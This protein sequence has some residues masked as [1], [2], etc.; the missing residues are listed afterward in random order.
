MWRPERRQEDPLKTAEPVEGS[1]TSL[2]ETMGKSMQLS[3]RRFVQMAGISAGAVVGGCAVGTGTG[4]KG[5]HS[6]RVSAPGS[7]AESPFDVGIDRQLFID[8]QLIDRIANAVFT[9]NPPQRRELVLFPET[10]WERGGITCYA[11][12]FWDEMHKQFRLYYVPTCPAA[13]PTFR[14]ALATSSDGIHW[15]RP[16]LGIVEFNGSRHNNIVIDGEREGSVFI[17]PNAPPERRYGYLSGTDKTGLCYYCSADGIHFTTGKAP[18]TPYQSDSQLSTFWDPARKKYVSYFKATNEAPDQWR[19]SPQIVLNDNI[20]QPKHGALVRTVARYETERADEPWTGP[21]RVVMARDE[22]D[23]EGMDLYTNSVQKYALAP[24]VYIGFPTPYYH[25]SHPNRAYLNKPALDAGGKTNDGTIDT[26]LAVSRDGITWTR[27]RTSYVP[28]HHHDELDL[29]I[30]MVF[31]GMLYHS[32][33]IDHYFAG[34]THTHGDT[35]ARVRLQ[36][37]QLGGIIRLTQRIDGFMSLDF[38]Y[39]GGSATTRPISFKGRRLVLNV[40]T[41]AAGEG[42]V[43]ILDAAGAAIDGLGLD[44]CRVVNGDH[45][46]KKVEWVGGSDIARLSGAPVRLRFE[47]RGAKLFSFWFEDPQS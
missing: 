1:L 28:L 30:C 7:R 12:V 24:N 2:S 13:T 38:P 15:E 35:Q 39:A 16:D 20:H 8:D 14:L 27:H 18:L 41:S 29:K 44:D 31:P 22:Q 43:A 19:M 42:R 5:P 10:P 17:D 45:L 37:R 21:F 33:R 46:E 9:V 34:Y 6:I 47:M 25:Y 23:P 26:Q 36:G 4:D 3:R 11:T 40:N 32:D